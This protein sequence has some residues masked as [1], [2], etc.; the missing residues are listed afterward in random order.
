M[1]DLPPGGGIREPHVFEAH[2]A[3]HLTRH[4]GV[5]SVRRGDLRL[6]QLVD[7]RHRRHRLLPLV[8]HLRQLLHG[9]EEL[10]EVEQERDHGARGDG[11]VVHERAAETEHDGVAAGGEEEDER[12]VDGLQHLGA[13]PGVEVAARRRLERVDGAALLH[14]RLRL[15]HAGDALLELGVD[16]GDGLACVRV[17]LGGTAP[18]PDRRDHERRHQHEHAERQRPADEAEDHEHTDEA[19]DVHQRGDQAGLQQLRE[20]VDV[21]GHA[22][23]DPARQLAVVVVERQPLQVREDPDAQREQQ[24]FRGATGVPGVGP[25][26]E[27]VDQRG[28]EEQGRRRP[29]R[30]GGV[31]LHAFV[32][33]LLD[34]ERPGQRQQRVDHDQREADEERAAVGTQERPEPEPLAGRGFGDHVDV[35]I[36][37]GGWERVDLREQLGGGC[38][39]EPPAHA[40]ARRAAAAHPAACD[41]GP[42]RRHERAHRFALFAPVPER[43]GDVVDRPHFFEGG[44]ESASTVVSTVVST[45]S[46]PSV[47]VGVEVVARALEQRAVARGRRDQLL[48]GAA[49]GRPPVGH[50]HDAVGEAQ[51]R[52]P[53]GDEHGGAV[54]HDLAQRGVDLLLG[55]RVDRRRGV[56][57]HQDPRVGDHRARDRDALALTARER[58]PALADDG[59]VPVGQ[60]GDELVRTGDARGPFDLVV[61]GVGTPVRDVGAHGVGEEERVLEHDADLARASSRA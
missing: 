48:V 42:G 23:H 28:D 31:L 12:E 54:D 32:E 53:V 56:V 43:S 15:A 5:D 41:G 55:A 47:R 8:E 26:D 35:G 36:V 38:E 22:G 11:P 2:V 6:H 20:R 3:A 9:S 57:E 17:G 29:Q 10:I 18:E 39:G 1:Q 30:A 24:P 16:G 13:Q 19:H 58:E 14:V 59:V 46:T 45:S 21:G 37:V 7:L 34:E 25:G 44:G 49:L 60:L 51:R 40:A 33:P 27:P 61:G 4:H 50:E 52:A